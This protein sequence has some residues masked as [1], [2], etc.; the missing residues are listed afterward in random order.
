MLLK[1]HQPCGSSRCRF[2]ADLPVLYGPYYDWTRKVKR[3]MVTVQLSEEEAKMLLEWIA[4]GRELD[5]T[6]KEMFQIGL[7][8]VEIIRG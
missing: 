3:K 1:H 7:D 5:R 2:H 8:A 6:V 4:N